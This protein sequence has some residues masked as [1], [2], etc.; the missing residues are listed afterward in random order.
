MLVKMRHCD[1][2]PTP[3]HVKCLLKT[4]LTNICHIL[5]VFHIHIHMP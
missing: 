4:L 3:Y 5:Y 1:Q 2:Q